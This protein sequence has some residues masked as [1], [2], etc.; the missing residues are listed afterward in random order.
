MME[1]PAILLSCVA[2]LLATAAV[3]VAAGRSAAAT[4]VVYC[5]TL[6]IS[7]LILGTVARHLLEIGRAHV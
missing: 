6:A 3:A 2:G 5:A 4:R 1:T 7:L